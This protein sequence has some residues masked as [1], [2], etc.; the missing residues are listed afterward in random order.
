MNN[1]LKIGH[2]Q[3]Q[4]HNEGTIRSKLSAYMQLNEYSS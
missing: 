2:M 3:E 1:G 4:K